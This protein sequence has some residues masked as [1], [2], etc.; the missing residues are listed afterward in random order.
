MLIDL[1]RFFRYRFKAPQA[2]G[3]SPIGKCAGF[4]FSFARV[5]T[6]RSKTGFV[7][8]RKCTGVSNRCAW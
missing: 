1:D 2:T 4:E 8:I 6:I 5:Q 7:G 3:F